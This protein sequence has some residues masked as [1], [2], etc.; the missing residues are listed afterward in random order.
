MEQ[1]TDTQKDEDLNTLILRE[2]NAALQE[3][4]R[5]VEAVNETMILLS[6]QV[7]EQGVAVDSI[8][9]FISNAVDNT[10]QG[11]KHLEEAEEYKNKWRSRWLTIGGVLATVGVVTVA[12][13]SSKK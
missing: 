7:N 6:Q 3:I 11:V 1:T 5:D 9:S 8:E 12:L 13:T 10:S 2:R 4:A